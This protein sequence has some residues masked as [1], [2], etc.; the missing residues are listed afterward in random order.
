V[1][2]LRQDD[3][4][5]Q[6]DETRQPIILDDVTQVPGWTIL[7]WLPLNRSWMGVPLVV[8]K[9]TIGMISITRRPASAFK[10]EET[11]PAMAFAGQAAVTLENTILYQELNRA[12]RTLEILD[13]AKSDFIEIVAHELRTP[14][15]VI[16]GYTQTL[17]SVESIHNHQEIQQ[18]LK[19]LMQGSKR[20]H[21]IV[22]T[23]LD[24]AK[25]DAQVLKLHKSTFS[26]ALPFQRIASQYADVLQERNLRLIIK[27]LEDLPLIAADYDLLTKVFTQ[28]V[29][30]AIKYTPDG[31][32]ITVSGTYNPINRTIEI[33]VADSGIGIAADRLQVIF[34]K[35][36]QTGKVTLHSSGQTKF[37]GGG[38]GLGL[39]LAR[40]LVVAH[41]GEIWADSPGYDE[42]NCPG[43]KFFVCLPV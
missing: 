11:W 17:T 14:L 38:P 41:G 30:N 10:S 39:P 28:L 32:K 6:L 15:T 33:I 40:G 22:N 18:M 43:S 16:I 31:G 21:E 27:D 8:N 9:R 23:M 5:Y 42:E 26:V 37:K 29:L 19:G 36:Y 4:Y 35:F 24:V 1:I 7:D 3:P 34:E 12:Y 25:L 20:M 13:K 2:E